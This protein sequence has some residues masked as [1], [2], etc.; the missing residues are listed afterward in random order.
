MKWLSAIASFGLM[1][2]LTVSSS[3]CK[4]GESGTAAAGGEEK[5]TVT[6]PKDTN[7][8]VGKK[9]T[10]DVKVDRKK[11]FDGPVD[12]EVTGLP[13]KV[14][15]TPAKTT[16]SKDSTSTTITLEAANEAKASDDNVVKVKTSGGGANKEVSF[17]L[18]IKKN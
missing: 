1:V 13:D 14:T 2:M 12:V 15:A 11:G 3:G 5:Y 6:G 7:I 9:N 10:I 16:I 17:K 4:K 18:S 8:T